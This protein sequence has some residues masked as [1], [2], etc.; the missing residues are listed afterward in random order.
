MYF[1][2]DD[3]VHI[4]HLLT[5]STAKPLP[6][7]TATKIPPILRPPGSCSKNEATCQ[8]GECISRDYVW[9]VLL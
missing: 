3:P 5:T 4:Q 7:T 9:S 1:L 6:I 8:N 2:S